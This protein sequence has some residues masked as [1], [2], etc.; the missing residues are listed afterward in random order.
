[1]Q[2]EM[3]ENIGVYR[4]DTDMAKAVDVLRELREEY[5]KVRVQDRSKAFNTDLLEILELGNLLDL[6]LITAESAR[7]RKESRGAHSRE[8]YPDRDDDNW[9]KHTLAWLD[10]DTVRI[11]YKPVD[12][13]IWEPKP[14]KY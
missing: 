5:K 4:N 10:Q 11:D 3:M 7:N 14:R 8:D 1:M 13:S 12:L 9:L 2:F 6:A